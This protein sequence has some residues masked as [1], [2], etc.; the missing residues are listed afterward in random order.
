MNRFVMGTA[1]CLAV[2]T[3]SVQAAEKRLDQTFSVTPGGRLT[4]DADG[5]TIEV[6]GAD[7]NQ[8]VVRIVATG[9]E[10][11]LDDL[12]LAAEQG[13]DG[14]SVRAKRR[15]SGWFSWSGS[16]Q[17]AVKVIVPKRYDVTLETSGGG[18]RLAQLQGEALGKTSGGNV[19]VAQV[20]GPVRMTTSGG[21][22]DVSDVTGDTD[23]HTSGG[24]IS[25]RGL[26]GSLLAR[27]SGGS[28][29]LETIEGTTTAETS[30]GGVTALN[31]RGGVD[32]RSSGGGVKAE[33]IDGGI[34]VSSSGGDIRVELI[35]A[36]RG[37][38]VSTTG[39]GIEMRVSRVI[40]GRLDAATSGGS[41]SSE[42]PVTTTEAR[43]RRLSG[44][45]NGGGPEIRARTSG[46]SIRL[47]ARD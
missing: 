11:S 18:I 24:G 22:I 14:V 25:V 38:N 21:S 9:S 39:G 2:L 19:S 26:R 41:V 36:N 28:I 8:V 35:G 17:M 4:V 10:S 15:A 27:T 42:L 23:I 40:A 46:G 30:G 6:T 1:I 33:G 7:A 37:I 32:L 20:E 16:R 43:E 44:T 3:F 45:I 12:E 29:Q 34:R 47:L 31:I 13:T 5:S